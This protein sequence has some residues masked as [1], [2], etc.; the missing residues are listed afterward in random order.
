MIAGHD[1]SFTSTANVFVLMIYGRARFGNKNNAPQRLPVNNSFFFTLK[2]YI[3]YVHFP[4]PISQH[5]DAISNCVKFPRKWLCSISSRNYFTSP[6]RRKK[7]KRNLL[8][9]S[10]MKS[11]LKYFTWAHPDAVKLL[12][13]HFGLD[14]RIWKWSEN[15]NNHNCTRAEQSRVDDTFRKP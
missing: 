6:R 2:K 1:K 4:I 11:E 7:R 10:E 5:D 3:C 8:M 12:W 13:K 14:C 9:L 15:I